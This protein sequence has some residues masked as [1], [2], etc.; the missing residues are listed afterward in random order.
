MIHSCG[1]LL[2]SFDNNN[3]IGVILGSEDKNGFWFN[4]KG[5]NE[6]GESY[7]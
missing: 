2:F 6:I 7:E 1:A 5:C 4:F 3:N